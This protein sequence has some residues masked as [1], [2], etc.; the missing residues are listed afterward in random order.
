MKEAF[1]LSAY[2]FKNPVF[3]DCS[4]GGIS[5]KYD[6]LLLVG[7]GV[8]GYIKV[9][10]DNPPENLVCLVKRGDYQFVEPIDGCSVNGDL[11]YMS[12]GSFC[13]T[14]DRRFPSRYP[15]SIHDRH[16]N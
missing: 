11:W 4:N 13:Y 5:E 10:L 8:E 3:S 14:S 15:L 9:D 2:V 6:K 16:E 12:G 7:K 1:A